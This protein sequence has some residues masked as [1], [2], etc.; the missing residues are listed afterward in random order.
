VVT[1]EAPVSA[2]AAFRA[3]CRSVSG[4][5]L[6]IDADG[7]FREVFHNSRNDGLLY[8]DP[9]ALVGR[10]LREV[11]DG[12]TAQRFHGLVVAALE[13]GEPRTLEY[14]L[15][16]KD[17]LRV[18]EATVTPVESEDA[19]LVL[20]LAEDVT[21]RAE[22]ERS[23]REREAHLREAQAVGNIGSWYVDMETGSIECTEQALRIFGWEGRTDCTPTDVLEPIHPAD[24]ETVAPRWREAWTGGSYELEF[25]IVVDGETRWVH[26]AGEIEVEDGEPAGGLGVVQDVTE[27][28]GLER[29][30]QR[31]RERLLQTE[32]LADVGG[33]E[34]DPVAESLTWTPGMCRLHG[35]DEAYEPTLADALEFY[36]PA[37]RDR[38]RRALE[39]CR[40]SGTPFDLEIRLTTAAGRER[41]VRTTGERVDEA[42]LTLLRGAV[43]DVTTT[44]ERTQRLAVLSR[45]LRHNIRNELNVVL[46]HASELEAAFAPGEDGPDQ[47][48]RD[49]T[50]ERVRHIENSARELHS[51]AEK[52]RRFEQVLERADPAERTALRDLLEELAAEYEDDSPAATVAVVGPT[53][54]VSG[55]RGAL[56]QAVDALVE[57]AIEHSDRASPTVTL[58][59]SRREDDR[60]CLAVEDEGPGMPEM[61]RKALEDG[62]ETPLSHGKGLGLWTVNWLVSRLGGSVDIGTNDPR[63]TVV[64]LTLPAVESE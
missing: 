36:H 6:L 59:V 35:V 5:G 51:L 56:R 58:R 40:A 38:L 25:R 16:V 46:G 18:F 62:R 17:G 2:E 61:E 30:L 41:K 13:T 28:K 24:R 8:D 57:N 3:F 49:T 60:V 37:D 34:Y 47:L 26:M 63:G 33:W 4:V 14:E 27:R 22:I 44:R 1:P 12:E 43:R 15:E 20:W 54:T 11:F 21:D 29:R 32:T 31:E 53:A 19:D 9:T 64:T 7:E 55:S 45:V 50:L 48:P 52:A 23:L 10:D 39:E 42:G